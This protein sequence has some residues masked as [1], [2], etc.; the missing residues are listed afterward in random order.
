MK[1]SEKLHPYISVCTNTQTPNEQSRSPLDALIARGCSMIR[2]ALNNQGL[3]QFIVKQCG[4]GKTLMQSIDSV[5][6]WILWE[7]EFMAYRLRGSRNGTSPY[8]SLSILDVSN[9]LRQ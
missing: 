3:H 2:G 4:G 8:G 1:T 6:T 5:W 9:G 7:E